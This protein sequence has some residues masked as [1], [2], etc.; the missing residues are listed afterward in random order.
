[1]GAIG[2]AIFQSI[3]GFRNAPSGI[4]KRLLGSLMAVKQRSPI[5]AE[6]RR[7]HGIPLSVVLLPV[8]YL[9]QEM[10][11]LQWQQ[12]SSN[13]LRL[14]TTHLNLGHLS[15]DTLHNA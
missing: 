2:G 5:I 6:E 8:V 12:N 11:Y 9:P 13:Q 7:T 10:V 3:K 15:K 1:M 4:N 14:P